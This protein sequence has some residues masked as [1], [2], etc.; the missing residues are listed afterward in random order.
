MQLR[1][2]LL[3]LVALAASAGTVLVA[4]SWIDA[5]LA[6]RPGVVE[7]PPPAPKKLAHILVAKS[8]LPAGQFLRPEHL[9][10]QP[11][12]EESLAETYIVEGKAQLEDFI[13]AIVRTG[14]VA[15]EPIVDGRVVR[16]GDRGFMAAVLSPGTR[17]V[18]V[19]VTVAAGNAG[20]V[21]PGDRVDVIVTLTITED[22]E[23][24]KD[25]RASETVLTDI[26]VLAVDQRADDQ[27]KEVAV[28]KTATLEVTPKQAEV[29]AVAND[30]GRLSLSLRSLAQATDEPA[31]ERSHTWD[32]EA[33]P[34]LQK[35]PRRADA[36]PKKVSLVRGSEAQEVEF[37]G[38]GQ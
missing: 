13:G 2:I 6:Q 14:I 31:P 24:G 26:R 19:P 30:M 33:A 37:K 28:A 23:A 18:T 10:W 35:A 9:K 29:V 38:H 5:R 7:A 27:K 3:V 16:P 25:R 36:A 8:D 11:W 32:F 20:F 15:G 17:A 21:F 34:V 1:R 4:R 22:K 12:P